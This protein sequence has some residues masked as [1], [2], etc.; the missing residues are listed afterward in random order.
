MIGD[1]HAVVYGYLDVSKGYAY[2]LHCAGA[3]VLIDEIEPICAL[4]T[5]MSDDVNIITA[6]AVDQDK[7]FPAELTT[8]MLFQGGLPELPGDEDEP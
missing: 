2:A 8:D 6:K 7:K 4:P 5:N 3:C 1:K